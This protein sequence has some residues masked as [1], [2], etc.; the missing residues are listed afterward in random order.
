MP[1]P[2]VA[3]VGEYTFFPQRQA[4]MKIV[5]LVKHVPEPTA[6][7]R[8][9]EDLTLDRAR[10]EGRLSQLDE[11]AVEQA[12]KLVEGRKSRA[13]EEEVGRVRVAAG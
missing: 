5:V 13:A 8:F 4:S 10:V 1:V 12:V 6:V 3:F 9:A 7:W 2:V 11:Y